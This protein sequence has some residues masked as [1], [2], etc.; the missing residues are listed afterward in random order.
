LDYTAVTEQIETQGNEE[1]SAT[2]NITDLQRRIYLNRIF[3]DIGPP[4]SGT[5]DFDPSIDII[6]ERYLELINE[7]F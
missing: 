5:L 3:T 1:M 2:E 7:H 4:V 6:K